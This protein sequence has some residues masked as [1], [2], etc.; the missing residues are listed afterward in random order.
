MYPT[1]FQMSMMK[2]EHVLGRKL[3][4]SVDLKDFIILT[5]VEV[6]W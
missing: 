3:K 2:R 6:A 1:D 4:A 5:G